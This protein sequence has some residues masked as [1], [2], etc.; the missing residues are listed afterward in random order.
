V[1][2]PAGAVQVFLS[3]WIRLYG[4]VALDVFNHLRFALDDVEPMFEAELATWARL[5]GMEPR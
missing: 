2:L 1:G 4:L 5:L 3:C